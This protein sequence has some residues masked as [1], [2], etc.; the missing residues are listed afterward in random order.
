M[1]TK[2]LVSSARQ[3]TCPSVVGGQEVHVGT[4]VIFRGFVT[5]RPFLVSM[6]KK[7]LKGQR[8]ASAEEVT[9]ESWFKRTLPGAL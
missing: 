8:F 2:Q 5:A 9:V 3:R 6:A 1:A 4:S 7:F